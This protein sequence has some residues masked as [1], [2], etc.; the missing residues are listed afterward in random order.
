MIDL[1]YVR[2]KKAEALRK[3]YDKEFIKKD[4]LEIITLQNAMIL[5]LKRFPEDNLQF[6]RGGVVDAEGNYAALSGL[7]NRIW[8]GY[9]VSEKQYRDEKVVYCGYLINQWSHF[10]VEAVTRLWYWLKQDASVD[11]YVFFINEGEQR[12]LK[13]NYKDCTRPRADIS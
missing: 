11:K 9:P 4:K 13:G 1:S 6:G 2:P 3:W 12:I 8:G 10:L 5:P 7:R